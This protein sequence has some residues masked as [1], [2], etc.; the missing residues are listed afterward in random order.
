MVSG[1]NIRKILSI[2][3]GNRVLIVTGTDDEAR[4]VRYDIAGFVRGYVS[5]ELNVRVHS[6]GVT[7]GAFDPILVYSL[8]KWNSFKRAYPF[9]G[10]LIVTGENFSV[11]NIAAGTKTVLLHLEVEK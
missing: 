6:E 10:V 9:S 2:A 8:K 5:S 11:S 7:V 3:I 1:K 4:A